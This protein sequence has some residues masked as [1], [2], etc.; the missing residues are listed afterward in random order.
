MIKQST[1]MVFINS[2]IV[3][4]AFFFIHSFMRED[5]RKETRRG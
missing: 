2:R 1:S 5:Q 3:V 4:V